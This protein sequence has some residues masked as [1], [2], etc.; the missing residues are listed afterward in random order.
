MAKHSQQP[1]LPPER[2]KLTRSR[3]EAAARIQERIDVGQKL[4]QRR[5]TQWTEVDIFWNEM[6]KWQDYTHDLLVTLFTTDAIA[7]EFRSAGATLV[8]ARNQAE[9]Y[10]NAIET[11]VSRQLPQLESIYERLELFEEPASIARLE[12]AAQFDRSKVFDCSWS[13]QC[14]ATQCRSLRNAARTNPDHTVG[15]TERG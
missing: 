5:P 12:E 9:A 4:A 13:R 6:R 15:A 14:G 8:L 7:K 2:A 10:K 3:G 11:F 1:P